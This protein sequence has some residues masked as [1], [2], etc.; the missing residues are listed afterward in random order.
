MTFKDYVV[1]TILI[2]VSVL[3]MIS[4][5]VYLLMNNPELFTIVMGV[6]IIFSMTYRFLFGDKHAKNS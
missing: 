3:A 4:S 1:R 6:F 2:V 5:L